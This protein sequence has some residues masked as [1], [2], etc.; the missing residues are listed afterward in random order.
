MLLSFIKNFEK[1]KLKNLDC[2]KIVNDGK[3]LKD[4]YTSGCMYRANFY[5]IFE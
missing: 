3:E 5:C 4:M 1:K 2:R